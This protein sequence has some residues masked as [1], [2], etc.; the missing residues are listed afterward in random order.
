L[1]ALSQD[2]LASRRGW[3]ARH[4]W[5]AC[6]YLGRR[7]AQVKLRGGGGG[8]MAGAARMSG[9]Q[10]RISNGAPIFVF[11]DETTGEI[12]CGLFRKNPEQ[13][14]GRRAVAKKKR[15]LAS[16]LRSKTGRRGDGALLSVRGW[17]GLWNV[18]RPSDRRGGG[19][20]PGVTLVAGKLRV[21]RQRGE[22]GVEK[23]CLRAGSSSVW[24][25]YPGDIHGGASTA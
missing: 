16:K 25:E 6:A 7:I 8:R 14:F 12:R 15:H 3:G 18:S 10:L 22:E 13:S 24:Q 17:G 23:G 1:L 19:K 21:A 5:M 4:R 20:V 11:L 2:I 9:H